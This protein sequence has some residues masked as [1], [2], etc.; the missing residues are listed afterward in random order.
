MSTSA[1]AGSQGG[2]GLLDLI[3]G[4]VIIGVAL[5]SAVALFTV[6]ARGSVD[7]MVRQQAQLIAEAYLEEILLKKFYD[8]DTNTVC[9]LTKEGSRS[10]YDNVCDYA[11]LS[12]VGQAKNQFGNAMG[13]AGYSVGVAVTADH[14][15]TSKALTN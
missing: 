4:I 13:P 14:T 6:T 10:F 9:T 3:L 2:V 7:P 12:D 1:R 5:A 15:G 11:G 8:P